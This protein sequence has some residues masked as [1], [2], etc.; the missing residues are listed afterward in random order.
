MADVRVD[1]APRPATQQQS[2][3]L[4][5]I[6]LPLSLQHSSGGKMMK[7]KM[8]LEAGLATRLYR[9]CG[10]APMPRVHSAPSHWPW[11][12]ANSPLFRWHRLLADGAAGTAA[13]SR[14]HGA[15]RPIAVM[16][17][18]TLRR[19]LAQQGAAG[20]KP[21]R[22]ANRD[23]HVTSLV[24][25]GFYRSMGKPSARRR[26]Q[27]TVPSVSRSG[28]LFPCL[29]SLASIRLPKPAEGLPPPDRV[30]CR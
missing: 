25:G 12:L 26:E 4:P 27:H 1:E 3:H 17:S 9:G 10:T 5:S 13:G 22:S 2:H 24:P 23:R 21:H 16:Q 14:S 15:V 8:I 20:I 19:W 30:W 29:H 11:S 6:I 28:S 18:P 7:G